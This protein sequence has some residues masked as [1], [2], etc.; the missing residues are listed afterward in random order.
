MELYW[1]LWL[2]LPLDPLKYL[3][4][5]SLVVSSMEN[6]WKN[7]MEC[8][9]WSNHDVDIVGEVFQ[10]FWNTFLC[11]SR[12]KVLGSFSWCGCG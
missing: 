5:S 8:I 7:N 3:K 11:L 6:N 12:S 2:E 1:A 10:S 4:F 9:T